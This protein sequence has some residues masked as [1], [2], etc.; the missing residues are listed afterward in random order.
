MV[1]NDIKLSTLKKIEDYLKKQKEQVFVSDITRTL[2]IDYNSV[3]LALN[4]L[5]K[6]LLKKIKYRKIKNG[7]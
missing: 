7:N 3:K 1:R 4:H 2:Q 5:D 6:G